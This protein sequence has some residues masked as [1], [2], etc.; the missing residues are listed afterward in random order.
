VD[1]RL[2]PRYNVNGTLTLHLINI[3][4]DEGRPCAFF[5]LP[6]ESTD[7]RRVITRRAFSPQVARLYKCHESND[8]HERRS[9][10]IT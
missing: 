9:D 5:A 4:P 6:R 8:S 2:H 10:E 3:G 7:N 1:S